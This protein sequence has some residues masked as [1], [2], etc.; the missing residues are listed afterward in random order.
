M[1]VRG[2]AHRTDR[3]AGKCWVPPGFSGSGVESWGSSTLAQIPSGPLNKCGR[4]WPSRLA[5]AALNPKRKGSI[6]AFIIQ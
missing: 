5:D 4:G 3:Q 2:P 6:V 1:G